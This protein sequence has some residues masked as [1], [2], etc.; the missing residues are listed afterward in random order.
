MGSLELNH[1]YITPGSIVADSVV[2]RYKD[3][4]HNSSY[5]FGV[6]SDYRYYSAQVAH[7]LD[8]LNGATEVDILW[9]PMSDFPAWFRLIYLEQLNEEIYGLYEKQARQEFKGDIRLRHFARVKAPK[10][11]TLLEE[12]WGRFADPEETT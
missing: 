8:P 5:R 1:N 11:F 3:R 10:I 12:R 4:L 9:S 2:N 7:Q 6:E